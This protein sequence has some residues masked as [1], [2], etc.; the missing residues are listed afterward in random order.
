MPPRNGDARSG[1]GTEDM[2]RI[3]ID[4]RTAERLLSGRLGDADLPP[5]TAGVARVLSAARQAATESD[6]SA[7]DT[8]VSAMVDAAVAARGME[9][10]GATTPPAP[11]WRTGLPSWVPKLLPVSVAGV[12]AVFGALAAAGALPSSAQRPVAD[13]VSYVGIDIPRPA[14]T[15]KSPEGPP[16]TTTTT[17]STTT[18]T[19]PAGDTTGTTAVTSETTIAAPPCAAPAFESAGGCLEPQ[20]EPST[21]VPPTTSTTH[22]S[23]PPSTS[24]TTTTV[25][26]GQ[27]DGS[28]RTDHRATGDPGLS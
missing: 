28:G 8:T 25:P 11:A 27:G 17:S 21:T 2:T 22:P 4:P 26:S 12:T 14:S 3:D 16:V 23:P 5:G 10:A 1:N 13:V 9:G 20:P 7:L 6:L 15:P 18:T 24:T 19:A